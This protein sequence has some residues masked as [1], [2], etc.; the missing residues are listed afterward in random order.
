MSIPGKNY[1][2]IGQREIIDSI[3]DDLARRAVVTM[4]EVYNSDTIILNPDMPLSKTL[5]GEKINEENLSRPG[6]ISRHYRW[7]DRS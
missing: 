6:I 2:K 1:L 7:A 3:D 5:Q 4:F